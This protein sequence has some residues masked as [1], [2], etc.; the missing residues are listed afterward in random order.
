MSA[1]HF[2]NV[3][4][5]RERVSLP[6][7]VEQNKSCNAQIGAYPVNPSFR[8]NCCVPWQRHQGE[9][10]YN[11]AQKRT[12]KVLVELFP[13]QCGMLTERR[14]P[15]SI[16]SVAPTWRQKGLHPQLRQVP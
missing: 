16:P 3:D 11:K 10:E 12:A 4:N 6:N 5:I 15:I 8:I 13:T 7:E 14:R 1:V 9:R 2:A